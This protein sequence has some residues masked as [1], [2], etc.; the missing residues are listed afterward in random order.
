MGG[1]T[2]GSRRFSSP[3][4]ATTHPEPHQAGGMMLGRFL[5]GLGL[6]RARVHLTV[7]E[8]GD[9]GA[10]SIPPALDVARREDAF[11]DGDLLLPAGFGR[12]VSPG[13]APV[14]WQGNQ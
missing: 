5:P 7:A 10:A 8:H 14:R 11:A 1:R 2:R 13:T 6:P 4:T 9:T 12:G 3:V